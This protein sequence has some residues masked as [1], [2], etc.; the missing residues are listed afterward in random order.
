MLLTTRF[1]D[2]AESTLRSIITEKDEGISVPKLAVVGGL[3][4]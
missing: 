3:D 2:V 1:F 4:R